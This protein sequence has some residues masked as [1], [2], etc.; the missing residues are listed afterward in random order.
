MEAAEANEIKRLEQFTANSVATVPKKRR[1]RKRK[2]SDKVRSDLVQF[3]YH[4]YCLLLQEKPV[5]KKKDSD[6]DIRTLGSPAPHMQAIS[7]QEQTASIQAASEKEQS[8]SDSSLEVTSSS[9]SVCVLEKT[10]KKVTIS[11]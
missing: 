2:E 4:V 6:F 9:D 1:K 5:K 10:V 8:T 7:E 3:M 11:M